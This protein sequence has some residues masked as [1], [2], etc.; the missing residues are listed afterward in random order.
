MLLLGDKG[1]AALRRVGIQFTE[2]QEKQIKAMAAA[3]NM[4]GAHPSR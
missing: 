2:Q 3:N 4:A 1:L